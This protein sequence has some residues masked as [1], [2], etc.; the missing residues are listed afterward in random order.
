MCGEFEYRSLKFLDDEG[1][2]LGPISPVLF[3]FVL[4]PEDEVSRAHALEM[5]AIEQRHYASNPT[6]YQA[7]EIVRIVLK[8][9]QGKTGQR[10]AAGL[11]MLAFQ[12]LLHG[13]DG[14]VSLYQAAQ[15]V[16]RALA[17]A[18]QT[19]ERPLKIVRFDTSEP[20]VH[21]V[22]LPSRRRDIEKAYKAHE[23]VAHILGSGL[24]TRI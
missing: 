24:I 2:L 1:K 21:G 23:S 19:E 5:Y 10:M 15:L 3:A 13:T 17:K 8:A 11:T 7:S 16:E 12:H 4:F 18:K 22:R 14:E 6:G 9:V 20:T